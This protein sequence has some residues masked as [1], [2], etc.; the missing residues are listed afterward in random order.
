MISKNEL[1]KA[2][3]DC[4]SQP[5]SYSNCEK[6][7]VFYSIYDK[8]YGYKTAS[9]KSTTETVIYTGDKNSEFLNLINGMKSDKIWPI[10]DE[11]M[12]TLQIVNP[13]LYNGVINKIMD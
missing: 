8:L 10:I 9:P 3:Q 1:L 12:Q 13:R 6:L 2:I 7:A 11:L 5:S 4:E